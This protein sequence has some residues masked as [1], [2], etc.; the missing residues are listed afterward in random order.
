M[1]IFSVVYNL[2]TDFGIKNERQEW[3]I[4]TA[5]GTYGKGE[6]EWR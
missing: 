2:N 4:G 1:A 5:G 3:K 6:G